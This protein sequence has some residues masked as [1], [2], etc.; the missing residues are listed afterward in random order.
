MW[1]V[2]FST[3]VHT[4]FLFHLSDSSPMLIKV[5]FRIKFKIPYSS[6]FDEN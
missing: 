1:M 4:K 2:N 3:T 5:I 6:S